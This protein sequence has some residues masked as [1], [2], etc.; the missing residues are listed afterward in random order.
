MNRSKIL[1]DLLEKPSLILRPAVYDAL[2]AILAEK[3]GFKYVATTGYGISAS[4]IGKPDVGLVSFGEML[5]REGVDFLDLL[6]A[7][8]L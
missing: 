5:D 1:R 6:L 8:I 2:S 3:V 7:Q 4:L